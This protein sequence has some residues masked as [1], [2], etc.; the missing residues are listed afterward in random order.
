MK[1]EILEASYW[2]HYK[3]AKELAMFLPISHPKRLKI[4]REMNS[5]LEKLN[6]KTTI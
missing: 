6:G 2:E 1:N 4:E 5:I 3:F